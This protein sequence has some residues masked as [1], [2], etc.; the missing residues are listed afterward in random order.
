MVDV[1]ILRETDDNSSWKGQA[2]LI[3]SPPLGPRRESHALP[4]RTNRVRTSK[5]FCFTCGFESR[6]PCSKREARCLK[7]SALLRQQPTQDN[8]GCDS[9]V[10]RESGQCRQSPNGAHRWKFG[11]CHYCQKAEGSVQGSSTTSGTTWCTMG[12]KCSFK[13]SGCCKCGQ[14]GGLHERPTPV[15]SQPS[16]RQGSLSPR[17]DSIAILDSN[18]ILDNF[19][20]QAMLDSGLSS[21][22]E[23]LSPQPSSVLES[24]EV[25]ENVAVGGGLRAIRKLQRTHRKASFEHDDQSTSAGSDDE[26]PIPAYSST[27]SRVSV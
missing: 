15:L 2:V 10:Y 13:S 4:H 5:L 8:S 27:E 20:W 16:S 17:P 26:A 14:V 23:S 6:L 1:R 18:A 7:C 24:H 9:K 12:G 21:R 19:S 11:K 25:L 3:P 22:R